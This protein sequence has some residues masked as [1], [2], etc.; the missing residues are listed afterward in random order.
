MSQYNL[1]SLLPVASLLYSPHI[2]RTVLPIKATDT[3][4]VV[5]IIRKF[6][7]RE[8]IFGAI[9]HSGIGVRQCVQ[10]L[11]FPAIWAAATRE[12]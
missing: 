5:S 2:K 10:V 12:E 9:W 1:L 7:P 4:H 8:A 3:T 6:V 11:A